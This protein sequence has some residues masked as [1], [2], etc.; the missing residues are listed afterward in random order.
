MS[1]VFPLVVRRLVLPFAVLLTWAVVSGQ[2]PSAE[3]AR[4]DLAGRT[5]DRE[6][7]KTL[8]EDIDYWEGLREKEKPKS[9]AGNGQQEA[10]KPFPELGPTGLFLL[11][12]VVI[13]A[14]AILLAFL[15]RAILLAQGLPKD[16]KIKANPLSM[17]QLDEVEDNLMEAPLEEL[18]RQAIQAGNYP[19]ALRLYFLAILK[20]LTQE[21]WIEWKKD[22]TNREYLR[23]LSRSPFEKDFSE[24][25]TVF[26]SVWY[27]AKPFN[28]HQ[29]EQIRP[30]LDSFLDQVNPQNQLAANT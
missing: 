23:E 18:I 13:L 14:A 1:H 2:N 21:Q 7:W 29:F 25:A 27:G 11:R 8:T 15:V 28:Q 10:P 4:E 16:K 5:F 17:D 19:V 30:L 12:F 9:K 22:K 20:A 3:Y 24:V 6:Q 26:N